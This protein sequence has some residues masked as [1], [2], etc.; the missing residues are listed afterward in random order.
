MTISRPISGSVR[1]APAFARYVAQIVVERC[2][3]FL[4]ELRGRYKAYE[5]R[6]DG[7]ALAGACRCLPGAGIPKLMEPMQLRCVY[8]IVT[9]RN[10][11]SGMEVQSHLCTAV[12]TSN[13]VPL[14]RNLLRVPMCAQCRTA[15][16]V[17]RFEPQLKEGSLMATFRCITCGLRDHYKIKSGA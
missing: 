2:R 17:D 8:E 11:G 5:I 4:R 15:M 14:R 16:S 12:Q 10:L 3:P 1:R 7:G 6:L 13:V 9:S